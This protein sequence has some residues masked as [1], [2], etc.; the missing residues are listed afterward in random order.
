MEWRLLENAHALIRTQGSTKVFKSMH[1]RTTRQRVHCHLHANSFLV[2]LPDPT[3]CYANSRFQQE[4]VYRLQNASSSCVIVDMFSNGRSSMGESWQAHRIR[5]QISLF[6]DN[7]LLL[8]E[9]LDLHHSAFSTIADKVGRGDL[10]GSIIV[11][12]ERTKALQARLA[13]LKQRQNW[14]AHRTE[15]TLLMQ[16]RQETDRGLETTLGISATATA[17]PP[18]V[19]VSALEENLVLVRF[20]AATVEDAYRLLAELLKPLEQ[21]IGLAAYAERLHFQ[22][23]SI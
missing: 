9:N 15:K 23:T 20:Q 1:L 13:T 3:T 16:Q 17:A 14:I 12:G 10:F 11:Y 2:F 4:Q 5:S 18:L 7:K 21:E 19:S 8:F 22:N 6:V